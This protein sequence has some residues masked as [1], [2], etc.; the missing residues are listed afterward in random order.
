MLVIGNGESRKQISIDSIKQTKI[1]C[2]AIHRDYKVDHLVCIDKRMLKEAISTTYHRDC[3]IY[4]RKDWWVN[5][6]L[7]SNL[8]IVPE[9][10]FEKENRYDEPYNWGSGSYA[11]LLA[12]KLSDE[13]DIVGFDLYSKDNFV[14]NIYKGTDNYSQEFSRALDP[15]YW[16]YQIGK[17]IEFYPSKKF[18]IFQNDDWELPERWKKSNVTVDSISNI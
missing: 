2:N 10:P 14:N 15:R 17:I 3:K 9:I 11:I 5:Y 6:R 12:A 7:E 16:I 1:G 18:T 8:N 13:I 4:T